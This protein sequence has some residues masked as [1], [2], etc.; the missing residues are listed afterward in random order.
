MCCRVVEKKPVFADDAI[1]EVCCGMLYL[2]HQGMA[3]C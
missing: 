1:T 3:A 2:V